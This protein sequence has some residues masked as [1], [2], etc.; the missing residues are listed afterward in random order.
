MKE[1]LDILTEEKYELKIEEEINRRLY[2]KKIISY[3]MFV[4]TNNSIL[5]EIEKSKKDD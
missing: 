1:Y 4:N 5:K 3:E 2:D